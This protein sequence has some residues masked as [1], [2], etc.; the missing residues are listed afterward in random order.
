MSG[1]WEV[2]G[3]EGRETQKIGGIIVPVSFCATLAFHPN[4]L[5][6]QA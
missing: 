4:F 1:G 6:A 2:S 3:G 5:V